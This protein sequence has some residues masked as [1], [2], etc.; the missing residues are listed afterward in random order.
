MDISLLGW[1]KGGEYRIKVLE[2]LTK[3]NFLLPS[4]IADNLKIHRSS[5]SRILADLKDKNLIKSTSN[6]SRTI[7]Y[8]ITKE[9]IEALKSLEQNGK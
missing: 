6:E 2:L 4:E 1:L 3:T 8:S 5:I 9:G 7:S